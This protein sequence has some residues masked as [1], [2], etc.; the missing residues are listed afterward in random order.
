MSLKK[1]KRKKKQLFALLVLK[2]FVRTTRYQPLGDSFLFRQYGVH[3]NCCINFFLAVH[4]LWFLDVALP[5]PFSE[6]W[7][8]ITLNFAMFAP[9]NRWHRHD[10]YLKRPVM[11]HLVY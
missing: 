6:K 4:I 1:K 8:L 2:R 11:S 3:R 10:V 5:K 9:Q 7:H